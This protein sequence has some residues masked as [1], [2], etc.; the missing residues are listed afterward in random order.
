MD[1]NL[2]ATKLNI[3]SPRRK[4]ISRPQILER[5]DQALF[6]ILT[7]LAAPPGYGKTTL[8]NIWAD[9]RDVPI[10]WLSLDSED[11][12]P[13]LFFQYLIAALQTIHPQVGLVTLSQLKSPQQ[14]TNK[15]ILSTLINDLDQVKDDFVVILD[16]YH[17][18]EEQRIHTSLSY[19]IDHLPEN[20]HLIIASR[21]DP[22]IQLSRLRSRDQLLE[23]RQSDLRMTPAE[24]GD[25]LKHSMGLSLSKEQV[26][27]LES[28]TEGWVAGLQ[29]AALSLK[30][31]DDVEN[32]I[33][34]FGGSHRYVIDYLA[35]EV[36]SQQ[37]AELQS[38][39]TQVA[40]LDRVSAPLCDQITD[41]ED[42][43]DILRN[44]EE[45]NLFLF[46]L[47]E[48]RQWYRFHHLFSDYLRTALG[49]S[50]QA[51]LHKKASQWFLANQLYAEAVKHA[52]AAG[53]IPALSLAITKAAPRL[54]E[55][56]AVSSLSNWLDSLPGKTVLQDSLLATYQGFLMFFTQSPE[57]AQPFV[58]A[59]QE[60][61]SPEA[62]SSHQGQLMSLRAHLALCH[63]D[64]NETVRLSRD[65][66]E[67][68]DDEDFFFRNL[69]MNILGQVLEMNGDVIS[70]S[71]IYEQA[72]KS[73]EQ[74]GDQ[75]GMLVILTNLVFSLNELGQRK[76]ALNFCQQLAADQKWS[77]PGGLDLVD[78]VYLPWSLLSLEANQLQLAQE[79]VERALKGAE[80]VYIAQGKLWGQ[81]LLARIHLANHQYDRMAQVAS[82]GR[83]LARHMGS[84]EMHY[85]WFEALE[86][87]ANLEQGEI[88]AVE[89]WAEAKDFS[90]QD[91]PHHWHEHEYF[92]YIRLL[93]AQD[94]IQDARTLLNTMETRAAQGNRTRK[95]ITINLLH[96]VADQLVG[97]EEKTIKHLETALTLAAPQ[98][99]QRAFL[100]EGPP[101]LSLLPRLNNLAPQFIDRLLGIS[102]PERIQ[103]AE[104]E[105][106]I[107]PLTDREL[108]ILRLVARGLS[109][110]EIAE[111]LFVT[112]GTVK[113]HLN[114]IFSK[115][116]VKSR[117]Q[118]VA[119]G[120][121]LNLLD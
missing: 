109:N 87:Q 53:D 3:P 5:L 54:F 19:L 31:K 78:G 82:K 45:N 105:P 96:T 115:L 46:P 99:Y 70:A 108:E 86:A 119:R 51:A 101:I 34:T 50:D 36:F 39:L 18:I 57:K 79:Q 27:A 38:F 73:G 117:T 52:R 55:Q 21:S 6:H 13:S 42:S 118:A 43:A 71:E 113:K 95:L 112:L 2:L 37:P 103:A 60:T 41:R 91:S 20:L 90:P 16:D 24:A 48:R 107:D 110:R 49:D 98:N 32:F 10:A 83:Q 1:S 77:S 65:A 4:F 75:L 84:Q 23:F 116:D 40:I 80:R 17:W 62:T 67:Y 29:L 114:N 58:E 14:P 59:A 61:L 12:D 47:D 11:N 8:L 102:R 33:E 64:L 69:T 30:G 9:K 15:A 35:D 89:R 111:T 28:R 97:D 85:A 100:D 121:E 81:Y 76:R 68:L 25:F 44:L 56:G 92:T 106:L 63:D 72:F 88:T 104:P 22:P 94:Q 66:L 93:L 7:L 74:A 26:S 120:L